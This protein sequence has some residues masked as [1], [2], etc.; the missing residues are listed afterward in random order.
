MLTSCL[1]C[2][3]D[4]WIDYGNHRSCSACKALVLD[5]VKTREV[6]L[7]G[8]GIN[9]DDLRQKIDD[10]IRG[11]ACPSC[12]SKMNTVMIKHDAVDLCFSCGTVFLN[13]SEIER[14]TLGRLGAK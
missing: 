12:S 2:E 9:L 1:D 7:E 13:R 4:D 10:S 14:V 3:K 6:L 11:D 5:E 8:H